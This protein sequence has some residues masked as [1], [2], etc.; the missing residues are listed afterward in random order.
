MMR[1]MMTGL[2]VSLGMLLLAA[3][4]LARHIWLERHRTRRE[5][6]PV[7][8]PEPGPESEPEP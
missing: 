2:L 3:G 8:T 1:W 6:P 5:A 4:G 7:P